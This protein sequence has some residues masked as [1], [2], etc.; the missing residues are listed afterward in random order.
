MA[1]YAAW[2]CLLQGPAQGTQIRFP[3]DLLLL[4]ALNQL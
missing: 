4:L 2:Q 3:G 1:S